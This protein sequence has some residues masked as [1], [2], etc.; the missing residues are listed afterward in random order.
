MIK[1]V[2]KRILLNVFQWLC[3][4]WCILFSAEAFAKPCTD[5]VGG[6]TD[7]YQVV[8]NTIIFNYLPGT[9]G[10]IDER[11]INYWVRYQGG[12]V[13]YTF[14]PASSTITDYWS[15]NPKL[16]FAHG[17]FDC[18]SYDEVIFQD[19]YI[20]ATPY[21]GEDSPTVVETEGN[22]EIIAKKITVKDNTW[23]SATGSGYPGR[24]C[25]DG[26]GPQI[27]HEPGG[28][29]GCSGD[30]SA[31]GGAHFGIGGKGRDDNGNWELDC[32][33]LA[34]LPPPS[35]VCADKTPC[36][37]GSPTNEGEPFFHLIWDLEYGSA[38]GDKG[39]GDADNDG[40]NQQPPEGIGGAGGG[41][42]VLAGITPDGL[43]E[44][45]I[46]SGAVISSD[47]WRGCGGE[48]IRHVGGTGNDSAGA[49]A[50]GSVLIVGDNIAIRS[51]ARVSASGGV[52]GDTR[53]IL[54]SETA[55]GGANYRGQFCYKPM[56]WTQRSAT[57]NSTCDD[58]AGGG[59][60][61]IVAVLSRNAAL[62]EPKIDFDVSGG[63]GGACSACQAE[64]G[65]G[66]G[67][68]QLSGGYTGETCDGYDNDFDGSTDEDLGQ[69][70]CD[71]GSCNQVIDAC[72]G[73]EWNFCIDYSDPDCLEPDPGTRPRLTLI[74]DTSGSMLTNLAGDRYTFG[75]GS[76]YHP[77]IDVDGDGKANDSRLYKAKNALGNVIAAYP[78]V[79]WALAR[80]NQDQLEDRSCQIAAWMECAG[81]C[82]TYDDPGNN[83]GDY[84]CSKRRR[85]CGRIRC[86]Y[87]SVSHVDG[88]QGNEL[89]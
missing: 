7:F 13:D 12:T 35:L 29:G 42:L 66:A 18:T 15:A 51:G 38:G 76:L 62:L 83:T 43:G 30:D 48:A 59:G 72:V 64:S 89:Y 16:V 26:A 27:F 56:Y 67:E 74:M 82:C 73:G 24:L 81:I 61:G 57:D 6:N 14:V 37:P 85:C 60:G 78:E 68:L 25:D 36:P 49:G 9:D 77:G 20:R 10:D 21:T 28:R 58:C 8:G 52:G 5:L 40:W 41:K 46:E 88:S 84:R 63:L 32:G 39:C 34:A 44:V 53:G 3:F 2:S 87:Q 23:I 65:G 31:G 11:D 4:A 45:I 55:Y 47:G 1:I 80:F 54:P 33:R 71:V 75:D 19:I 79:D 69:I 70:T 50:G 22:L 17:R 86:S